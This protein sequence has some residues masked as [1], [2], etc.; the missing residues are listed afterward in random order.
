[1]GNV[2]MV[3]SPKYVD[4][5]FQT[6]FAIC[7]LESRLL[8]ES[9]DSKLSLVVGSL[10]EVDTSKIT[11][12]YFADSLVELMEPP[13]LH[14]LDEYLLPLVQSKHRKEPQHLRSHNGKHPSIPLLSNIVAELKSERIGALNLVILEVEGVREQH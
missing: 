5:I 11:L 8:L 1:M 14:D 3:Q 13:S 7:R 10:G 12:A 6:L 4:L 9:F 2:G